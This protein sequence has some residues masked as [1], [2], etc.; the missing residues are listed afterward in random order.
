MTEVTESYVEPDV[1]GGNEEWTVRAA[2]GY[3][4]AAERVAY[5]AGLNDAVRVL[6]AEVAAGELS[7]ELTRFVAG[8]AV[9]ALEGVFAVVAPQIK[10]RLV[11]VGDGSGCEASAARAFEWGRF[12]VVSADAWDALGLPRPAVAAG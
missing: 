4:T 7:P 11:E 9:S 10:A 12:Q 1:F 6:A 3:E 8:L 2:A 5:A